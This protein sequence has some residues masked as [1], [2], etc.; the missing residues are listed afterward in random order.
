MTTSPPAPPKTRSID[1]AG[2]DVVSAGGGD[3]AVPNNN[4]DDDLDAG[5]GDDL[6]VDNAVCDGDQLEAGRGATTPTGQTSVSAIS[7]DMAAEDAGLVGGGSQPSCA[8]GTLTSLTGLEDIEATSAGDTMVGEQSTTA[9]RRPGADTY[10]AGA[11]N[12]SILANSGTPARTPT[13]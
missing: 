13:R 2:D 9:P 12:D 10:H 8:G 6:F 3:D 5:D 11:G 1:G 4:G 7:I